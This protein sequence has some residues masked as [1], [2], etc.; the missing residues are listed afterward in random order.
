VINEVDVALPLAT[1]RLEEARRGLDLSE[2]AGSEH[3]EYLRLK[4]LDGQPCPV[5][6]ATEHPVT[7]VALLLRNRVAVD[8]RRVAELEEEVSAARADR[9][10]AD[11]QI[12][13]AKDAFEGI[14]GRQ[15]GYEQELLTAQDTWRASLATVRQTCDAI[16]MVAPSFVEDAAASESE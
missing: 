1:A 7:D 5:C 9:T 6:G 16:G 8:R 4:L 13:A 12:V 10:R 2:A 15:S 3:A 11:T 14:T